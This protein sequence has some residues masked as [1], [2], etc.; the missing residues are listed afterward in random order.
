[1]EALL[2]A[3]DAV[4]NPRKLAELGLSAKAGISGIVTLFL[5]GVLTQKGRKIP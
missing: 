1:M 3:T 4:M 5:E 2:G